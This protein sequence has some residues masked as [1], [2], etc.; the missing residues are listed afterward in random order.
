MELHWEFLMEHC[1]VQ[2]KGT[3][4]VTQREQL[5]ELH[6]EFLMENHLVQQKVIEMVTLRV[7]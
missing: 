6:W 3:W 2:K 4:M 5:R 7:E 1:L